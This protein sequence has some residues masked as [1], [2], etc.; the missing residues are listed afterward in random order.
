VVTDTVG[1]RCPMAVRRSDLDDVGGRDGWR[2]WLCDGAVDPEMP[3]NDPR[4]PSVDSVTTKAKAKGP[5]SVV[6]T[7]RLAHRAC[8]TKK[9]AVAAVVPWAE[10]LDVDAAAPIRAPAERLHRKGGREVM[11]RCPTDVDAE[12]A[13]AWLVDR[14]SR[15]APTLS[16]A[17]E[18]EPGGGQYLLVLRT[19]S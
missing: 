14:M 12:H 13:A 2:C 1:V 4:G 16:V 7:E 17:A 11:A 19:A 10:D 3:V 5:A 9:G 15:L 8:N 6:G 18:I